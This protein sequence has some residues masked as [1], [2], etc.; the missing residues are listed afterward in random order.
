MKQRLC[1]PKQLEQGK[2]AIVDQVNQ[3][4]LG[5]DASNAK[6][7]KNTTLKASVN[8]KFPS[9][10]GVALSFLSGGAVT[11]MSS[12]AQLD[13][14][15]NSL[16]GYSLNYGSSSTMQAAKSGTENLVVADESNTTKT[17][18]T[19]LANSKYHKVTK[20]TK[21]TYGNQVERYAAINKK[22]TDNIRL[23]QTE[24]YKIFQ[25]IRKIQN[26][27][28]ITL[29]MSVPAFFLTVFAK[30]ISNSAKLNLMKASMTFMIGTAG[31]FGYNNMKYSKFL[32][33]TDN[34]YFY[35]TTT[36]DLKDTQLIKT[37][38]PRAIVFESQQWSLKEKLY[39]SQK[40]SKTNKKDY[41]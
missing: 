3:L 33:H 13:F 24:D 22:V 40:G 6:L 12:R 7:D 30:G 19:P 36:S 34:K 18:T 41:L 38:V 26:Q 17:S 39:P 27:S 14:S 28:G 2:Q 1:K 20:L 15:Q 32:Y 23:L 10:L 31:V 29:M 11:N 25:N 5:K 16:N 21:K 35:G 4:F 37:N 8:Q 9:N